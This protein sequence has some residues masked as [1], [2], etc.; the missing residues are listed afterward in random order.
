V[1]LPT[2]DEWE[3]AARGDDVREYP[4]GDA[5][6]PGRANLAEAGLERTSVVGT[7]PR[8][9]SPFGLLDLAGNVDEWTP[10]CIAPIPALRQTWLRLSRGRSTL[11]SPAGA[12]G[13]SNATSRAAPVA[14]PFYPGELGAGLR[15]VRAS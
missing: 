9:A 5:F 14:T 11:T 12:A 4:W 3:R 15:L 13:D 2:E 1:R 10:R 8:G 7:F 6:D